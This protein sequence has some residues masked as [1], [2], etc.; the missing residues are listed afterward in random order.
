MGIHRPTEMIREAVAEP[1]AGQ[2][3]EAQGLEPYG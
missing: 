1:P 3:S 2:H